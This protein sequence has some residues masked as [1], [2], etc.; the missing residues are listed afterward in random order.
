MIDD[1]VAAPLLLALLDSATFANAMR[2]NGRPCRIRLP[3]D[4]ESRTAIVDAHLRGAPSTLTFHANG[5]TPWREQV[6]AVALAAFCPAADGRHSGWSRHHHPISLS[7]IAAKR[8]DQPAQAE[9]AVEL[10]FTS[11]DSSR[12]AN[13]F[14]AQAVSGPEFCWM[15]R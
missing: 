1:R 12:L 10:R 7:Q 3:D 11:M 15:E 9:S 14:A 6:D 4:L 2:R 8:C 13:Y 5:H